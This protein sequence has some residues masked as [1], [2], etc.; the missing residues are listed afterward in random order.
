MTPPLAAVGPELQSA[1][2]P[3]GDPA[4]SIAT[5]TWI[6]CVGAAAILALVVALTAL[7]ILAPPGRRAWLAHERTVIAGGIVFPVVTLSALLVYDV[8]ALEHAIGEDGFAAAGERAPRPLPI[9]IVGRQW[10]WEVHYGTD[11]EHPDAGRFETANEIRIPTGR[12][13]ELRLT[14][15]D[16]VHSLWIPSLAGKLDLIPGRTNRLRLRATEPAVHRGQCAEYCGGAHAW[17]GIHVVALPPSEFTAWRERQA[18][19]AAAP[20]D[21]FARRGHDLFLSNG[22]MLC[23]R[24]RGTPAAGSVGPD[25]THVGSRIAIGAGRLPANAGTFAGWVTATQRLKP[26]NH[27]PAF[28]RFAGTDLRALAAWLESLE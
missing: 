4:A 22:C 20:S 1:L 17:M 27:M 14:S 23:H 7:A 24:V 3:A 28:E 11:P 8:A 16:V 15:A 6:L 18:A 26:R 9:E 12:T 10:W 5:L 25:L 21:P 2:A 19:P 13:V